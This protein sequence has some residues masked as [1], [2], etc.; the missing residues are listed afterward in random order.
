ML[1]NKPGSNQDKIRTKS[2]QNQDIIR[3]KSEPE[4][5][6]NHN[7]NNLIILLYFDT[8]CS[9]LI[10]SSAFSSTFLM[11]YGTWGTYINDVRRF[12]TIFD[13]PSPPNHILSQF[14]SC[15]YYM[16]SYFDPQTPPSHLIYIRICISF[17]S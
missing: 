7:Q 2:G 13:P 5:D 11:H 4:P 1:E 17:K 6:Q 9:I 16:T 12:S 10:H 14:S 3:T 8:I 15:P